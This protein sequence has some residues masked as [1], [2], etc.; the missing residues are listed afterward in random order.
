MSITLRRAAVACARLSRP[1]LLPLC[2]TLLLAHPPAVRAVV[3]RGVVTDA[4][5]AAVPGAR[6]QLIEGKTTAASAVSGPD[7]SFEVRS[8]DAGRF[9]LL[10]SARTFALNVGRD[11]YGGRL[12]V[13]TQDVVLSPTEIRTEISVTASGIPTPLPQLTAPVTLIDG[14]ELL[15]RV[16]VLD[17]LRQSPGANVVQTGQ[18]GG[19]A[20]LFVRGANS[21]ANKIVIDGVPAE[22]IGGLFDFGT[23]S[24]TGLAGLEMYR[25]PNSAV[26]GSDSLASVVSLET[27][28]GSSLKPVLNYSG[29]AGTLN[30]WRNEGAVSGTWRRADYYVAFSRFDTS[31]ALPL[32]RYHSA[33][34]AAN[35]GYNVTSNTAVRLTIRNA[36]SATGLPNAHDF[37]EVE[38]NGKQADQDLYAGATAENRTLGGWHNLVRYGIARKRE[39][40]RF[41]GN[42]GTLL[43][44]PDALFPGYF[45]NVVQIRGANDT[46]TTG[47]AE[48]FSTDRENVSNRDELYY[49]SDYTFPKRVT[50]LFGFRYEHERGSFVT[51]GAFALNQKTE[52]TNFLYNLQ[53]QGDVKSRLFYS[54][55]GAVE[56]NHLFG[57]AGT[58]RLGLAYVPVR[59]ASGY[60]HGTRLRANAATGVQEPNLASEFYSLYTQLKTAGDVT[61][62]ALYRVKPLGPQRSRTFDVGIDQN[63]VGQKL[64]LKAGYFHSQFSHQLEF[65]GGG[66]LTTYFG[67]SATDPNVFLFGAE[68]NSGA[69]RAQGA[70]VALEFQPASRLF[71][72]GGYTYLDAVVSQSFASDA[73]AARGGFAPTNPLYPDTPIGSTSPLVGARPFRRAPHTGYFAVQYTGQT[74][75]AA[76]KAAMSSRSDDSTFLGGFDPQFGNTLLLPNRD[77]DFG[78]VKLDAYGTYAVTHRVTLF[79]ELSNLL[80]NQHIGPIGYP[81]LPLTARGGVKVRLGGD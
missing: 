16:G 67:F 1:L 39:Q 15:T 51:P 14:D 66:D 50:A 31:N 40:A 45:G 44:P 3:V 48:F 74:Y 80:N 65:V 13:V 53:L 79:S 33:T 32:D 38:Q 30:T 28:R 60:F 9:L 17:D 81:S 75:T 69:F 42:V 36:V 52:R 41:F 5:G 23:V 47:R 68:L 71:V 77:L 70:E 46:A 20:S 49:Q 55:G 62:I 76:L 12:D 56:K 61:D 58:P 57:I 43:E 25:G 7:G 35:L 4:L 27:P 29:D 54:F 6:V 63:L 2:L 64:V 24:S 21:D 11:F 59:P 73:I 22:D 8:G 34:S 10:T 78:W 37:Y 72:R 19:I 26:Y 18:T